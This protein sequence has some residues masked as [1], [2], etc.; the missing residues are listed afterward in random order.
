MPA[1]KLVVTCKLFDEQIPIEGIKQTLEAQILNSNP[2]PYPYPYPKPYP[3]PY[4]NP[5]PY[6]YP[7]PNPNPR[8]RRGGALP[9]GAKALPLG[10]LDV[11]GLHRGNPN[12]QPQPQP[13]P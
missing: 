4:P 13:Q 1:A 12:P 2:N 7:Y 11:R 10:G 5:Y 8:G 3:Y 6:P 9:H